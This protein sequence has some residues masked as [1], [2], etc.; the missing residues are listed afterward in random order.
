[1]A[2]AEPDNHRE[3]NLAAVRTAFA[4]VGAGDLDGQLAA[5]T[6]DVVLEMPFADPPARVTG[7]ADIRARLEPALRTFRFTLSI[8]DIYD[9]ADPDTLILEYESDGV[10]TTT[11]KEYHNR[12]VGI[13]RFRAGLI[14]FQREYYNPVPAQRALASD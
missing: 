14:C 5:Y 13:F 2:P 7:K 8:T 12:Y 11:G 10:V 6:D 1:V 4:A 3:R 9:C